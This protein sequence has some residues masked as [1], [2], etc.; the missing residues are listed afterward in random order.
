ML[1]VLISPPG[2]V[3]ELEPPEEYIAGDCQ[4]GEELSFIRN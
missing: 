4:A 1:G 3:V 2:R